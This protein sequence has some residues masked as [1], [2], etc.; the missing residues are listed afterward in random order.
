MKK[1]ILSFL[2]T[3]LIVASMI[4][5]PTTA[6][7]AYLTSRI[8]RSYTY[9]TNA[10]G[11]PAIFKNHNSNSGNPVLW[12]AN[13]EGNKAVYCIDMNNPNLSPGNN[14]TES[15]TNPMDFTVEQDKYLSVILSY[16]HTSGNNAE[17]QI[18]TQIAV[19]LVTTGYYTDPNVVNAVCNGFAPNTNIGNYARNLLDKCKAFYKI[20]SFSNE[21]F[22]GQSTVA[23]MPSYEMNYDSEK[24]AYIVKLE[25][26]NGVVGSF[27]NYNS[28]CDSVEISV[29]DDTLTLTL[30]ASDKNQ[31]LA[32]TGTEGFCITA[33]KSTLD[34]Q[35]KAQLIYMTYGNNQAMAYRFTDRDDPVV[36]GLGLDLAESSIT[37]NKVSTDG[38]VE[39]LQFEITSKDDT[40]MEPIILTTDKDGATETVPIEPGNYVVKELNTPARYVAPAPQDITVVEGQPVTLT[41]S[42]K[43]H[44]LQ[45][46]KTSV[47]GIVEGLEFKVTCEELDFE[48]TVKTN[49]EGKW[50]IVGVEPGTYII[51]EIN[52]PDKYFAPAPMTVEVTADKEVF[53]I[54]CENLY[55]ASI[56]KY[57]V[58]DGEGVEGATITITDVDTEDV[59]TAV[60]GEDGYAY[61]PVRPGHTYTYQETIGVDGYEINTEV[62]SFSV[63]DEGYMEGDIDM[64]EIRTGTAIIR[65][66]DAMDEAPIEGAL[67]Q[68]YDEDM[69]EL[70]ALRTDSDGCVYFWPGEAGSYYYQEIEPPTG[71]YLDEDIYSFSVD[72]DGNVTGALTFREAKYGTVII[73]KLSETGEY[74]EG[75]KLAVYDATTDEK[76]FEDVTDSLGR[77]YFESPIDG[78]GDFYFIEVE[79]PQGYL[80]DNEK[81]YFSLD[82]DYQITGVTKLVNRVDPGPKTGTESY[83]RF[84]MMLSAYAI[85]IA[86]IAVFAK[87]KHLNHR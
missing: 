42:N 5:V 83:S 71:Y 40:T 82:E 30:P 62:Y 70:E 86:A 41:F 48:K 26:T 54:T 31:F 68:F 55:K 85:M 36:F 50:E 21:W 80:K 67:I 19:W 56:F 72:E 17:N 44:T 60:T 57:D 9:H 28:N 58:I 3:M 24:D 7:A 77:I 32:D 47:D 16:G 79:A 34:C 78:P 43:A 6:D 39:G 61:A 52:V 8:N 13:G 51:E 10:E 37:I 38:V 46:A 76:L 73:R 12:W 27:G 20:P 75:A 15:T 87:K 74:L 18:G 84:F 25:D 29:E 64:L 22:E 69:E 11:L 45:L 65:K 4:S 1:R 14:Y 23:D 35:S 81:H 59:Y 49:A 2:I 33:S 63:T 53:P 66:I